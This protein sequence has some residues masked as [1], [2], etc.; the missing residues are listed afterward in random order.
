MRLNIN[1]RK[2]DKKDRGAESLGLGHAEK[3]NDNRVG[4]YVRWLRDE[5]EE[6]RK[7]RESEAADYLMQAMAD[8]QET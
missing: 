8:V 6:K 5:G 3:M 1:S 4:L 2:N 7:E